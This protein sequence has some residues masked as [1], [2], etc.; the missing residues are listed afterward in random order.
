MSARFLSLGV[1]AG[2]A[3]AYVCVDSLGLTRERVGFYYRSVVGA[4][5]SFVPHSVAYENHVSMSKLLSSCGWD[6]ILLSI[7]G[8]VIQTLGYHF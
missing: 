8:K 2:A 6:Q 7:Y 4:N 3:T 1:L 5:Q